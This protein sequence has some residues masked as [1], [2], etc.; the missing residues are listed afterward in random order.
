M[1]GLTR[2]QLYTE[3]QAFAET[4]LRAELTSLKVELVDCLGGSLGGSAKCRS[5][6]L[7]K[8]DR[9][10]EEFPQ[11]RV[12]KFK[13]EALSP[14]ARSNTLACSFPKCEAKWKLA[15]ADGRVTVG[16]GG[17]T[18]EYQPLLSVAVEEESGESVKLVHSHS[19]RLSHVSQHS[20]HLSHSHLS[21]TTRKETLSAHSLFA[22][23]R[24]EH[25]VEDGDHLEE[26][27]LFSLI[28]SVVQSR[29]FVRVAC[30]FIIVNVAIIGMAVHQ[31]A[32]EHSELPPR[33]YVWINAVCWMW[34]V[35]ETT[36]RV[37]VYRYGFFYWINNWLDLILTMSQTI[38][39]LEDLL[40]G[41]GLAREGVAWLEDHGLR[42]CRMCRIIR[43]FRILR[44]LHMN[45]DLGW[46]V[47]SIGKSMK[48][49]LWTLILV[50]VMTYGFGVLLT[51]LVLDYRIN[52]TTPLDAAA[53]EELE[54]FYG[55]VGRSMLYL[56]EAI[57]EGIHWGD[58]LD[59][60]TEAISPSIA[61]GFVLYTAFV[62]FAMM[63]VITSFFVDSTIR[64]TEGAKALKTCK[65]VWET[66][67]KY[68]GGITIDIFNSCLRTPE[69][70]QYLASLDVSADEAEASGFFNLLDA[71]GSG[72]VD[73]EELVSGCVR[74]RGNAK[75]VDL[76]AFIYE[77]RQEMCKL[78]VHEMTMQET[79]AQLLTDV[80]ALLASTAGIESKVDC[81]NGSVLGP[82]SPT[83]GG[84]IPPVG[85]PAGNGAAKAVRRLSCVNRVFEAD[86][87]G[88]GD[89]VAGSKK[90]LEDARSLGT[91][92]RESQCL[93]QND[94]EQDLLSI[95]RRFTSFH[96]NGLPNAMRRSSQ[97]ALHQ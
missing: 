60:L 72:E 87:G 69:M 18:G 81:S 96:G 68:E 90:R 29:C 56:Y 97:S 51:H 66:F 94:L 27:E 30:F 42:V 74:L 45:E 78:K 49:L 48:N 86:L 14:F 22:S 21:Y 47:Q 9:S 34:F 17:D 26:G 11:A 15:R 44:V 73:V 1:E 33:W 12:V 6:S 43:V 19:Q 57:S 32:K 65:D 4:A 52:H 53:E 25:D 24:T 54:R 5:S 79:L 77:F 28:K 67:Q 82:S 8:C 85:F 36:I 84:G 20:S 76:V 37:I 16:P 93:R 89:C 10:D 50:F 71:D 13:K 59:P 70:E 64:D 80:S 88:A 75:Q 58:L 91:A 46:L 61:I 2:A 38:E 62:S 83:D 55:D 3:L 31:Q 40:L 63:N 35:F 95:G 39:V 41:M 7:K 92:L 23:L